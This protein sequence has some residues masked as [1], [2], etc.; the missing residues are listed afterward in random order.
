MNSVQ[1]P[2]G[3]KSA[4]AGSAGNNQFTAQLKMFVGYRFVLTELSAT[5]QF[6][7]EIRF[8]EG[9]ALAVVRPGSLVEKR[10]VLQASA[11]ADNIL[12]MQAANTGLTGGS[13]YAV[14]R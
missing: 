13:I 5:R 12:H 6:R 11:R 7:R 3:S 10:C 14:D 8:G 2:T 4:P 1:A 9:P